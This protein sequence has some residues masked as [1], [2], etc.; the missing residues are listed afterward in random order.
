MVLAQL[1]NDRLEFLTRAQRYREL[2][3]EESYEFYFLVKESLPHADL[4]TVRVCPAKKQ[5]NN[6]PPR[7]RTFIGMLAQRVREFFL[8]N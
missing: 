7:K 6:N 4:S 5:T 1:P 8:G 2:T 3:P